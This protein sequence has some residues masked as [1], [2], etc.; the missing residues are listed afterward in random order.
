MAEGH[1]G[2][3]HHHHGHD[4]HRPYAKDMSGSNWAEVFQRQAARADLVQEWLDAVGVKAGSTLIDMGSGPGFN[5]LAAAERVGP[6]GR[7]VAVDI[8]DGALQ[9][10]GKLQHE[11]GI[12]NIIR[13]AGD[14]ATVPPVDGASGA[15]LTLVL[16]HSQNPAGVLANLAGM[17]G[18]GARTAVVEFDPNGPCE[19]GPPSNERLPEA[20]VRMWA[21]ACG[22]DVTEV[23]QQ[24]P[25]HYLMVLTRR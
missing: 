4:E 23:R 14:G 13:V 7:V 25:E 18:S 10:L 5:S 3:H 20:T 24:T 11:R 19:V 1:E 2:H 12:H 15:L 8:A 21:D 16:H 17:L 9:H 22:F 6:Q